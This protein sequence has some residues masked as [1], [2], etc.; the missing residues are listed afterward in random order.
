MSTTYTEP[1]ARIEGGLDEL[2]A[3]APEFRTTGEKQDLLVGLARVIARAQAE[4]LRALATADDIAEATGERTTAS[5]LATATRDAHGRV[6][7]DARLAQA[8]DQ[9]WTQTAAAFAAGTLNLAQTRVIT[10]ALEALPKDLGEDLLA[11]AETLM[12]AEADHLGPRELRTFGSRILEYLAP[13]IAEQAEYERLLAAER[14][15][16]AATRLHLRRRGDGSTD[17]HARVPDH[18]ASLLRTYLAAFT[19]PRRRHLQDQQTLQTPFGPLTPAAQDEFANLPLARQHGIAFVALLES[20]LSGD[21]PRHGGKATSVSVL[22]PWE[23]LRQTSQAGIVLTS[24]G[25]RITIGQARRL[26]SLTHGPRLLADVAGRAAERQRAWPRRPPAIATNARDVRPT[27][28]PSSVALPAT[29]ANGPGPSP[30]QRNRFRD[31]RRPPSST[32]GAPTHDPGWNVN[33]HPNGT[34]SF[35]RRQ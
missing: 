20:V 26:A 6:R 19:A 21:L 4:Q 14:R 5:W 25:D 2:A 12:V 15:A 22:I 13:E 3:I 32:S 24:T 9:R 35:T 8:L 23:N 28:R 16:A 34:T 29:A 30:A 27:R 7:A 18:T 17:L 1:L 31:G 11:K 33:H 10:D